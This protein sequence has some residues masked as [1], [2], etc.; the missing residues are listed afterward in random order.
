MVNS[1]DFQYALPEHA[2]AKHPVEPRRAARMVMVRRDGSRTHHTFE[3]LPEL[4]KAGGADGLWANDTKVLHA[5]ILATKPT[6]GQLEIFLLAPASGTVETSLSSRG[7]MQWKAMVRNAK[8]WSGGTATAAGV[9]H[10]L[11]VSRQPDAEDG[12]RV[13]E[14]TWTHAQGK[15]STM[16]EVLEDLGQ[17]PLPPYMRRSAESQD[18]EDYQTVFALTPGSVAAPTAGLHYDDVLLAELQVQG[19]PL[20]KVT[21]HVGAGT[22]KPLSEGDVMAHDM[23][24]ERCLLTQQALQSMLSQT[25]RVATGTTTLRTLESLYWWSL[26]WKVHGQWP[27]VLPQRSP[28]GELGKQAEVLNWSDRDALTT[29]LEHGPWAGRE[30][31]SF[32]TQLMIVPG[33]RIRM[34][35]GLVTNFHQ[36]GSTLLCLV[37]AFIGMA[38]WRD[39]YEEA[40]QRGY[41]FLSYGDGC[42]LWLSSDAESRA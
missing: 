35:Q 18:R 26:H 19:L 22:F 40:L 15:P 36:P 5:R 7:P 2:I 42:L 23:H 21:L 9:Q 32:E 20:S 10:E 33:Y 16:A 34:V 12:N 37:G 1:T 30:H 17:T 13:V 8:R 4:L 31:L 29:I 41:R 14:L 28:Y 39:M 27:D 6:G 3:R 38:S 24:A 11:H 25:V